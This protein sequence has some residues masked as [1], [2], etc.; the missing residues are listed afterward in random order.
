MYVGD[1][2]LRPS[3][4]TGNWASSTRTPTFMEVIQIRITIFFQH[5]LPWHSQNIFL[6][7]I[8]YLNFLKLY[9][10]QFH[11][12]F[13]VKRK[14]MIYFTEKCSLSFDLSV[15]LCLSCLFS[16]SLFLSISTSRCT[17]VLVMTTGLFL[18]IRIKFIG[19]MILHKS[20]FLFKGTHQAC[21]CQK[22]GKWPM[23]INQ[24]CLVQICTSTD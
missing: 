3:Q 5:S 11:T 17:V 8:K 6:K 24:V 15:K 9:C 22:P 16:F 12:N 1:V 13:S 19:H 2:S 4:I 18:L 10:P 14:K 21:S 20:I 7:A 23:W